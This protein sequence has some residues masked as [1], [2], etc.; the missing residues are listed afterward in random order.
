MGLRG[1]TVA[2]SATQ[3][4]DLFFNFDHPK[5]TAVYC[6]EEFTPEELDVADLEDAR[7]F[8]QLLGVEE[9]S[10]AAD[11]VQDFQKRV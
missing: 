10:F 8:A 5:R 1:I 6:K 2:L 4:S 9:E 7:E 3:L 11:L